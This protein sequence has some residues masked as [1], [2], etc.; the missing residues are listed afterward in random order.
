[1]LERLWINMATRTNVPVNEHGEVQET[2]DLLELE[3]ADRKA[4]RDIHR[5]FAREHLLVADYMSCC[6]TGNT[7]ADRTLSVFQADVY[8]QRM[9]WLSMP[10]W[11]PAFVG[12]STAAASYLTAM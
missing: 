4:L 10:V 6:I 12:H 5:D 11:L 9:Y 3:A 1:M 8:C 2:D 7:A